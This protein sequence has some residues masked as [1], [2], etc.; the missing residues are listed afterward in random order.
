MDIAALAVAVLALAAAVLAIRRIGG[1]Q[2]QIERNSGVLSELRGALNE[3]NEKLA[4]KLN[5]LQLGLRRQTGE[6]IFRPEMT[7]AEALQVHPR[8]QEV[9][10]AFHLGSCSQCAVSDV[11]T[12]QGACQS[13]G[14][15][16]KALMEALN[17]LIGG[18]SAPGKAP[19]V[20]LSL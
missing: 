5:D 14:I 1:L 17:G 16:Q 10:A 8:V 4:A 11:D 6:A 2:E 13:Y 3:T 20:K 19:N 9:L 18:V 12:I 7:I 15:D